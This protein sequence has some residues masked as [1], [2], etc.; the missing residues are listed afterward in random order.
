MSGGVGGPLGGLAP[1]G[2]CHRDGEVR[3][4]LAAGVQDRGLFLSKSEDIFVP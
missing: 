4:Q 1:D 3:P 2:E